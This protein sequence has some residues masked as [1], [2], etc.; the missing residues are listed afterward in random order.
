MS[1]PSIYTIG[2]ICAIVPEFVAARLFLDEVH[3][4]P[5]SLS[6]ND[7]NSYKLGRMG[8]HNVAIAVLPHGG[9]GETSAAMV[10][11][12][13]VHTFVNI[14]VGLMVGIGGGAPSPRNDVRLGDIVVSSPA[15]GNGGVLQYDFGKSIEG[16][17]FEMTGFLNQPPIALR[18]ALNILI[19][20]MEI[21]GNRLEDHIV[22]RLKTDIL[23]RNFGRPNSN[24]DVLFRSDIVYDT[25][26]TVADYCADDLVDRPERDADSF[27]VVHYGLIAS[28][29][30]VM[31][32]AQKRDALAKEKNVLCFEMEAAGLMNHFPCLVIRGICDYSDSHKNKQWQG[33][34]AMAAA[35]FAKSLVCCIPRQS[36]EH[37]QSVAKVLSS[38]NSVKED[39]IAIK[40]T[41]DHDTLDKLPTAQGAEFDSYQN[42]HEPRCHPSTRVDILREIETWALHDLTGQRLYWLSGMAG[43]GKSIIARTIAHDLYKANILGA[44]FFFK[45]G[46]VDRGSASLLFGTLARQLAQRRPELSPY[47]VKAIKETDNISSKSMEE[48]FTKLVFN[49]LK[50][51]ASNPGEV[52]NLI[53]VL[54]ALDECSN[55]KDVEVLLRLLIKAACFDGCGLKLLITSRPEVAVR[56]ACGPPNNGLYREVRLHDTPNEIVSKDISLYLRH[57]LTE[58]RNLW[59]TRCIDNQKLQLDWPGQE[60]INALVGIA[61]PLFLFAAIACRFIRDE[62][63]GSPEEQL[64]KLVQTARDGGVSDK[65]HET[66]QPVLRQFRG[67]RTPSE[68][69]ILLGRFREVIGAIILL[70]QPLSINS[71]A[72]LLGLKPSQVS[73]ILVP[74]RSVLDLPREEGLE[75]KLFHSS[76]RDF[77]LSPVAGEFSVNFKETHWRMA[78][79]CLGTLSRSLRYNICSLKPADRRSAIARDSTNSSK[80]DFS[81]GSRL[82]VFSEKPIVLFK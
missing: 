60:K 7:N 52:R 74:L 8:K 75:V 21:E 59:N 36:L 80:I 41:I 79:A 2:W 6:R 72:S 3:E 5:R 24:S 9:Y 71:I 62:L 25:N 66:Y 16:G 50:Q 38:I 31:K 39:V 53:L 69:I 47:I 45:R 77:L 51:A 54:D 12:D 23:K 4:E 73:G 61:I 49:P 70:E 42:Q 34:A 56:D 44:T 81:I 65:L 78:L 30:Q 18:T 37:E 46:E 55:E 10:A 17:K 76:F 20:D 58:I 48:Q 14:R 68:R 27:P 64:L 28:A 15:D 11:R 26:K 33:Y 19:S 43:T 29:N 40:D 1:D 13:M 35:S 82:S 32:D 67:G 57:Q 63:F 22:K